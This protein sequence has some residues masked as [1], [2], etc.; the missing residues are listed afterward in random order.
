MRK[1]ERMKKQGYSKTAIVRMYEMAH[2]SVT[3]CPLWN[4][5]FRGRMLNDYVNEFTQE[6]DLTERKGIVPIPAGEKCSWFVSRKDVQQ[7]VKQSQ[8]YE[9]KWG[10]D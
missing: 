3:D 9:E 8:W 5:C 7:K 1:E 6:H 10:M 2:C 4:R